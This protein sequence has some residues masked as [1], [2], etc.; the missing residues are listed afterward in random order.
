MA[1]IKFC[2]NSFN[3]G[4]EK[5]A[6]QLKHEGLNVEIEP[7]LGYCSDCAVGPF[8]LVDD[9]FVQANTPDEL[10]SKIID[11]IR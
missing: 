5:I 3:Q 1:N 8:S 2:E 10:Y 4:T 7:C 9:K 11:T 6:N